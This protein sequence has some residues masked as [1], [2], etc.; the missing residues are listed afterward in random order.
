MKLIQSILWIGLL[1]IVSVAQ[2]ESSQFEQ[3]KAE[4]VELD[5][6]QKSIELLDQYLSNNSISKSELADYYYLIGNQ[7]FSNKE[8]LKS[9]SYLLKSRELAIEYGDLKE[10]EFKTYHLSAGINF[11]L[12]NFIEAQRLF[13]K[14]LSIAEI[15]GNKTRITYCLYNL[16]I[17]LRNQGKYEASTEMFSKCHEIAKEIELNE[18]VSTSLNELGWNSED[19]GDLETAAQLYYESG[20][21]PDIDIESV[22][23]SKLNVGYILLNQGKYRKAI[24]MFRETETLIDET[25][26]DTYIPLLNNLGRCYYHLALYD[27]AFLYLNRAFDLN[28]NPSTNSIHPAELNESFEYL[29]LVAEAKNDE[30]ILTDL[31][32]IEKMS[33]FNAELKINGAKL[34]MNDHE[35]GLANLKLEK[36]YKI[37]VISACILSIIF[38]VS[39]GWWYY[40][41]RRKKIAY[42]SLIDEID[43]TLKE[44]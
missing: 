32:I 3:L 7:F 29:K 19:Q 28:F 27:S 25:Y 12:S 43:Q 40:A 16:G 39:V 10:L 30:D 37:W 18:M 14:A 2:A 23:G 31:G 21:V 22:A 41:R 15:E 11:E 17:S 5:S 8:H 9:L 26:P 42:K 38:L 4:A 35:K 24:G 1:S 36:H 34:M 33:K 44:C 20:Q 6:A 13:E